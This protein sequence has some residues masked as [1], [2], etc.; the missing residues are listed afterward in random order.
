MRGMIVRWVILT[1]GI[2]MASYLLEGIQVRGFGSAM[3]AAAALGLLNVFFRP[4]LFI[5]T[6]PINILT[7]GLFTFVINALLLMMASGVIGGFQ[8]TGFWTAVMGSVIISGINWLISS[9]IT[10]S[11]RVGRVDYIEMRKGRGGWEP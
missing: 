1:G 3:L 8:V 10:P 2:L 5:L 7:L 9:F 6:L 4:I 11:G